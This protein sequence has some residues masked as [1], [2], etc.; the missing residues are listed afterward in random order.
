MGSESGGPQKLL[1][2]LG[3]YRPIVGSAQNA[4]ALHKAMGRFPAALCCKDGGGMCVVQSAC[5]PD[6]IVMPLLT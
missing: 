6:L 5:Q 4:F 2:S 1:Q 3:S